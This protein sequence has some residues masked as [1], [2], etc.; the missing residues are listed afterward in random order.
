MRI[1][2]LMTATVVALAA[3][4]SAPAMAEIPADGSGAQRSDLQAQVEANDL[5]PE[6]ARSLQ[7]QVDQV[8]ADTGGTQVAINQVRWDGGDTLIP[9]PGE[10]QAR[11]LG[12]APDAAPPDAC[13]RDQF[14][15]YESDYY[16]GIVARIAS[17]TWHYVWGKRYGSYINRLQ[18]LGTRAH[19]YYHD[20]RHVSGSKPSPDR[21]TVAGSVWV[22]TYYI[23]PC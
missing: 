12:V 5:S 1:A 10:T 2:R 4:T 14:C 20:L 18:P 7:A 9:L 19:F 22:Q 16:T 21:G 23:R 15:L 11:E 8:V 13:E 6:E 3:L 17:C